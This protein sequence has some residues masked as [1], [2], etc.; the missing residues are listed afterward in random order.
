MKFIKKLIEICIVAIVYLVRLFPN[1]VKVLIIE[2]FQFQDKVDYLKSNIYIHVTSKISLSRLKSV[3]KEPKTVEWIENYFKANDTF[4]DVGANVGAYSL[5]AASLGRNIK[6]YSFE[7]VPGTFY[8]LCSN[9][10][11]NSLQGS[12]VPV[13]TC[14]SNNDKITLF[15]MSSLD[16]GAGL[17]K[18]LEGDDGQKENSLDFKYFT[19][20]YKLD[21]LVEKFQF[22]IP[23]HIKVDVDGHELG[24]LQGAINTLSNQK[25]KSIQIEV[26]ENI[27]SGKE[28]V[29]FIL[30]MGFNINEKNL[31]PDTKNTYDYIFI[32]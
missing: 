29:D 16:G 25:V 23:N 13:N 17:H 28:I 9:I 19:S 30:K 1:K 4:F 22:P 27:Q 6:V 18:G 8:E 21:T 2:K 24:V 20:I 3:S 7:P 32:K 11:M 10:K 14:L 26:D 15:T 12:I 5:I 31:H